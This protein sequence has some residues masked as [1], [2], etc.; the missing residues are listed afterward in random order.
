MKKDE[1]YELNA[2]YKPEIVQ[3]RFTSI[4]DEKS[5]EKIIVFKRT[6]Q[7]LWN[8][9]F[10]DVQGDDWA[11]DII[12]NNNDLRTV[13]QTVANAVYD[14]CDTHP[15]SIILI[16]PLE[17]QRKLLYNRIFKLKWHEIE[18]FFIVKGVMTNSESSQLETFNP[19][20]MFDYFVI[21]KKLH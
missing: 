16:M 4:S 17:H 13:L 14:F 1:G 21:A 2:D 19:R 3:F 5:I 9:G 18:P 15:N 20:K 11:D 12:T 10:G 7:N 6:A 8:L